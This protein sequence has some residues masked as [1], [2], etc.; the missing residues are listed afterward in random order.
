V[1]PTGEHTQ[2]EG[3]TLDLLLA[4]HFPNSD[5]GEGGVEPAA[6]HRATPVDWR[7]AARIITH[8]RVEWALD[9]FS[10]YKSPGADWIFP[11]LLQEGREVLIPRLVRI[12]CACLAT[13]YVPALWRQVKVVFIPKPGRSSHCGPRDFRPISLTS[14][15]LKTMERL[16]DRFLRDEI[17][18]LRP[19]HP[20]QHAYQAGKSVETALHQL[21]VRA[22]K[23]LDQQEIAL[24]V[25]LD[26]EGAFDNT[27]Y[28]SMCTA[29]TRHEADQTIVRWIRAT[30]EGRLAMAALGDVSRSVACPGAAPRGESYHPSYGALW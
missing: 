5:V 8:R 6:A 26:T 19:L 16:V 13:R 12:F 28:D 24:G 10:P 1:A 15:L 18:V 25:F 11:A 20:N 7:V 22:E 30:L 27:S 21:M 14:F 3:E 4:T 17:L 23:A 2:S 29:L 9:S